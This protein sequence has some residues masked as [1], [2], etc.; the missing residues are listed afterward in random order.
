MLLSI[1]ELLIVDSLQRIVIFGF[2]ATKIIVASYKK[3]ENI[4]EKTAHNPWA[5]GESSGLP[6]H[7]WCWKNYSSGAPEGIRQAKTRGSS[8]AFLS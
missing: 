6:I 4:Y 8:P 5:I 7:G 2:I 3:V 1:T